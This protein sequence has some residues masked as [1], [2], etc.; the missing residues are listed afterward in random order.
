MRKYMFLLGALLCAL[1]GQA[2][3]Q[4]NL[5]VL[6]ILPTENI[7]SLE[8]KPRL[9]AKNDAKNDMSA[10]LEIKPSFKLNKHWKFGA[11]IPVARVGNDEVSAKGLGDIMV[12]GS[13]VDYSPNKIFSYGLAMELTTPTATDRSLGD[14][15]WVAEPEIFTVW[16]LS[17]AFF[18]EAEYRHIFSFAGS[19]G[20]DD[21]NESRYRMIFGI[22]GPDGWWFEFDP[23]YTVDYENPGEAELIG[24]FELGTMINVGSSMYVRGGWHLG[25]NKYSYDWEFM[26][27]FKILY[28]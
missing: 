6:D 23:R 15:K 7:T 18:V 20:R 21:I 11:E 12:S 28:L 10:T 9:K 24:E 17:P 27:G 16:K 4:E 26:M 2:Q 5:Q 3:L 8:F 1:P 19:S 25:G 14:G 22:I 13:Y